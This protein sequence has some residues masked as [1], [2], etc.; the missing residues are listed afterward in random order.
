MNLEIR[1]TLVH[2]IL[3]KIKRHYKGTKICC[4]VNLCQ[5]NFTP[6]IN[7]IAIIFA[8]R[9]KLCVVWNLYT[10][11]GYFFLNT[12]SITGKRLQFSLY[13]DCFFVYA[14]FDYLK[15][16]R[17]TGFCFEQ[18]IRRFQRDIATIATYALKYHVSCV[19]RR[20]F[21]QRRIASGTVVVWWMKKDSECVRRILYGT[22]GDW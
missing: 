18:F 9:A 2:K 10:S 8:I 4:F 11:A 22:I 17:L 16:L 15:P 3:R 21:K 12:I 19:Y 7:L 20:C 14:K 13:I 6:F 5:C 1:W